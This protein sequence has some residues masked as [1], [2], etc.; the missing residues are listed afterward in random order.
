[1]PTDKQLVAGNDPKEVSNI[2][3]ML[4]KKNPGKEINSETVRDI[5]WMAGRS[6]VVSYA[7]FRM[8]EYKTAK[9]KEP[10]AEQQK[11]IKEVATKMGMNG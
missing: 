10:T 8:M 11:K 3:T 7:I 5:H 9:T 6:R 4:K 1:M 2:V